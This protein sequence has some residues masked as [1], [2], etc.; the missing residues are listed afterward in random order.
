MSGAGQNKSPWF[1]NFGNGP[2]VLGTTDQDR[3]YCDRLTN[4]LY[5]F[6]YG[7]NIWRTVGTGGGSNSV[8][9]SEVVTTGA[10]A[11]VDFQAIPQTFRD[12]VLIVR[13]LSASAAGFD[14]ATVIVN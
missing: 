3:A 10:Q 14:T 13:G 11:T 7:S 2:P 9:I 8:L 6:D 5:I 4:F 1:P 12:L